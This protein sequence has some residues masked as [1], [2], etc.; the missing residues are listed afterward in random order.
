MKIRPFLS[1]LLII[2]TLTVVTP[3]QA[4]DSENEK[5]L[6]D[7]IVEIFKDIEAVFA[8]HV[9]DRKTLKEGLEDLFKGIQ[10]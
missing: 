5:N 6:H 4:Y 9:E 3:A 7:G 2:G 1:A 8:W 10:S